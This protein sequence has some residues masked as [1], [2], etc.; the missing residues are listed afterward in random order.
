MKWGQAWK[1]HPPSVSAKYF[2]IS[3][4]LMQQNIRKPGKGSDLN[5]CL[6]SS[7]SQL[8]IPSEFTQD[9]F[10]TAYPSLV[11]GD[12]Q[13]MMIFD[14]I[15][16]YNYMGSSQVGSFV[17]DTI[18]S[19]TTPIQSID[20]LHPSFHLK[21]LQLPQR[22]ICLTPYPPK[23]RPI[24]NVHAFGALCGVEEEHGH[25]V[26][27][28]VIQVSQ[29]LR[30]HAKLTS[31][32]IL[33]SER[34]DDHRSIPP[35]STQ[36][37]VEWAI[38]KSLLRTKLPSAPEWRQNSYS[39]KCCSISYSLWW[40]KGTNRIGGKTSLS[41]PVF[42]RSSHF[43]LKSQQTTSLVLHCMMQWI[44]YWEV[45]IYVAYIVGLF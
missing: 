30:F 39:S 27:S 10:Q 44:W 19:S 11:D 21:S 20:P 17:A 24:R 2:L 15:Q 29:Y 3:G 23:L 32:H 28:G 16:L 26:C 35:M 8:S 14:D 6:H 4:G 34:C 5:P 25:L 9:P 43:C 18:H 12:D 1:V 33:G 7:A 45:I 31:N 22:I 40:Y 13:V 38:S 41:L 37:Q 42:L 36:A